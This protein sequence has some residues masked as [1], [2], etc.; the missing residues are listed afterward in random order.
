MVDVEQ[1]LRSMSMHSVQSARLDGDLVTPSASA[2]ASG[3]GAGAGAEVGLLSQGDLDAMQSAIERSEAEEG[4]VG[5][6]ENEEGF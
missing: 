2:S 5:G 1:R 4:G 3:A 6:G